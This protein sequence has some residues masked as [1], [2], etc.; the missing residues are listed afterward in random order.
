M[1]YRLRTLLIVFAIGPPLVAGGYWL[2]EAYRPK[3]SP[4]YIQDGGAY[5]P[6]GSVWKLSPEAAA[7]KRYRADI[8]AEVP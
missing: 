4:W 2:W 1:R 6:S 5:V 7:L 3:P 8:E